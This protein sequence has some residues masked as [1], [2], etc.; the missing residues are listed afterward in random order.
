MEN[1][2]GESLDEYMKRP[3]NK[4]FL[5]AV[6]QANDGD[7]LVFVAQTTEPINDESPLT[8]AVIT[9]RPV[10]PDNLKFWYESFSRKFSDKPQTE[11][12]KEEK[13]DA[14]S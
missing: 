4:Y 7:Q 6:D 11:P 1:R 8:W 12:A 14:E 13:T 10:S 2:I 9:D 5:C 3:D